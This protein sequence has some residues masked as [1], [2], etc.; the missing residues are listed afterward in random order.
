MNI[1]RN[2]Y[3]SDMQFLYGGF[4]GI[5]EV[6]CTLHRLQEEQV[7]HVEINTVRTVVNGRYE[8]KIKT[9]KMS[10]KII[11]KKY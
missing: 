5:V 6:K 11:I 3:H 7:Y 4:D 9:M 1:T 8:K 2:F 10:I